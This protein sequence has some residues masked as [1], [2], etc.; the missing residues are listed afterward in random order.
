MGYCCRIK[1]EEKINENNT[2]DLIY[3]IDMGENI[4]TKII[5]IG[6]KRYK[7]RKLQHYNFE[8][9]NLENYF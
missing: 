8:E 4:D 3:N 7:D 5:F 9:A 1:L 6:D 2:V